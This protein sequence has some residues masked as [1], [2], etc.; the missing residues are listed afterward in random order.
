MPVWQLSF[1]FLRQQSGLNFIISGMSAQQ[2]QSAVVIELKQWEKVHQTP[3][4]GIVE[5]FINGAEREVGHPS[6]QAWSYVTMLEDFNEAVREEPIHL[7][8]C[9]YL[10]NCT[11]A[12]VI[13]NPFYA[14]Y[15]Q[16]APSFLK[17]EADPL[18]NFIRD[19]IRYGDGGRRYSSWKAVEF[20]LRNRLLDSLVSLLRGNQE[21]LMVDEQKVVYESV[22][23]ISA[24][25]EESG[26]NRY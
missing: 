12:S 5:T 21:F 9:A 18:R 1:V 14:K 6:Y 16:K 15:T 3:K 20:A 26:G 19:H 10:H 13:K 4:D 22:L 25:L 23:H 8:A 2:E 17:T 24:D 11:A 7:K